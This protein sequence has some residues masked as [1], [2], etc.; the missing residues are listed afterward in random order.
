[1]GVYKKVRVRVANKRVF[2]LF[3]YLFYLP[4]LTYGNPNRLWA[5]MNA[6]TAQRLRSDE[7]CENRERFRTGESSSGSYLTAQKVLACDK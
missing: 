2:N 1:M 4:I 3:R 6:S 5:G 7:C